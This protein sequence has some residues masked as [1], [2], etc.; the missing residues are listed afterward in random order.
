MAKI[1]VGAFLLI[2]ALSIPSSLT[3]AFEEPVAGMPVSLEKMHSSTVDKSDTDQ[4]ILIYSALYGV[5]SDLV[6][7][8]IGKESSGDPA[9]HNRNRNGTH[10][11]GLMQ[12]NSCN[13]EWLSEEL[14]ITDF[15]EPRQNIRAGCYILGLLSKKY[16][17]VHRVL[18]SYNM[19]ESR[20]RQLWKQRIYSSRYSREVMSKYRELRGGGRT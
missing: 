1:V 4:A 3:Y 5:D 20:T 7:A 15:Y 18:M 19:G 13:F 2:V 6:K 9:A 14:G 10:D 16:D 11:R 8:V 12:I 17:N